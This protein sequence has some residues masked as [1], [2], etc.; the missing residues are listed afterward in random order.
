[1][2]LEDIRKELDEVDRQIVELYE[3]RM[4]LA[5][6]VAESKRTNGKN[7][8]DKAREDAKLKSVSGLV[9]EPEYRQGVQDLFGQL[10]GSSRK[11][12]YSILS[13]NDKGSL[14]FAPVD[15]LNKK[16]TVVFRGQ[17]DLIRS[18]STYFLFRG[19]RFFSHGYIQECHA[20]SG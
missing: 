15:A 20:C 12:Q 2:E 16:A 1:M 6:E 14:P 9:K 11:L 10:M 8:F 7:V 4:A 17:K 13:S 3:K 18:G 19:G 5:C